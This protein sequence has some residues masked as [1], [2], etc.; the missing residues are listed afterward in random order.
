M[1][2]GPSGTSGSL[3]FSSGTT[4]AGNSGA[5]YIGTGASTGGRGGAVT[6]SVGTGA[7]G[8]GGDL[9]LAAGGSSAAVGGGVYIRAGVSTVTTSGVFLYDGNGALRI[10]L[11][12]AT[13][14]LDSGGTVDIDAG[15]AVTIDATTTITLSGTTGLSFGSSVLSGIETGTAQVSASAVTSS[16][17][18]GQITSVAGSFLAAASSETFVLTNTRILAAT[19]M[20]IVTVL[21]PCTGGRVTVT[22][23]EVTAT[24]TASFTVYNSDAIN[25]C[26]STYVLGFLVLN[27]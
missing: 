7:S 2:A 23:S 9:T 17:M 22:Q 25:A 21:T 27:S 3:I 6:V 24:S 12:S 26:T 15:S 10:T 14:K 11:T 20:V 16:T 19:S 8:A 5:I 18:T 13:I 4:S 1:N